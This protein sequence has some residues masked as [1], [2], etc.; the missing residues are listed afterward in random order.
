MVSAT[1]QALDLSPKQVR[2][3]GSIHRAGELLAQCEEVIYHVQEL[4]TI[5]YPAG[6]WGGDRIAWPMEREVADYAALMMTDDEFSTFRDAV[7]RIHSLPGGFGL[8]G[9]QLELWRHGKDK[10]P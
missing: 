2:D 4:A 1:Q 7:D 6:E 9:L 3:T 8:S 10:T 5:L